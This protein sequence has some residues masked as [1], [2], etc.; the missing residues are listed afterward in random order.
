MKKFN[1]PAA[2][3]AGRT[4]SSL[5]VELRLADGAGDGDLASALRYAKIVFAAWAGEI[6]VS[7]YVLDAVVL[8]LEPLFKGLPKAGEKTVFLLPC[9]DISRQHAKQR[10]K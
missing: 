8:E 9:G 10:P 6:A 7:F 1:R 3:A 5:S 2:F 4:I